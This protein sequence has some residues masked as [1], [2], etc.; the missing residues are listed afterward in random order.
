M[1]QCVLLA[2]SLT[3]LTLLP[4]THALN[5]D[6]TKQ[7]T[8]GALQKNSRDPRICKF[9]LSSTATPRF[10]MLISWVGSQCIIHYKNYV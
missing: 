6:R 3:L 8:V 7:S 4:T 1:S 5:I 9:F 10:W 2:L